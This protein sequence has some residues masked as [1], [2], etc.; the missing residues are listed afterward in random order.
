[1]EGGGPERVNNYSINVPLYV[2]KTRRSVAIGLLG[3]DENNKIEVLELDQ[4]T[5]F[6]LS[7]SN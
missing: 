1:M 5:T 6:V 7:K 2:C 3:S 4:V